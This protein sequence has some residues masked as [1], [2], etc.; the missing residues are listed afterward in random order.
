MGLTPTKHALPDVRTFVARAP[1]FAD[2]VVKRNEGSG[3]RV[4]PNRPSQCGRIT[5]LFTLLRLIPIK[6]VGR[7]FN[8]A[9]LAVVKG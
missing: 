3:S 1:R 5:L 8:E 6:I 7:V 9:L 2:R 4:S